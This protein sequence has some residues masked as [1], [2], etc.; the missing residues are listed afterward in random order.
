MV[1]RR[2]DIYLEDLEG[3]SEDYNNGDVC[4]FDLNQPVINIPG[5]RLRCVVCGM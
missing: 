5:Q 3:N 2:A 4:P 1:N